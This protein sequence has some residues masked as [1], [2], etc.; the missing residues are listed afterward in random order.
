MATKTRKPTSRAEQRALLKLSPFELKDK[1]MA[2]AAETEEVAQF[3]MLN[4]GRGN[5]N[6]ICTTPREAFGTLLRFA[7]EESRRGVSMPDARPD[8]R[9]PGIGAAVRGVPGREPEAPGI[10]LLR[11]SCDYGV[12][13]LKF[14]PDTFAHEL[15]EG[16][17][18][19]MYPVPGRMLRCSERI[20]HEYLMQEMCDGSPPA[21]QV[22]PLRGRR[23]HRG[24]VLHLRLA[25]AE[26][27]A[28]SRRH[29]RPGRADVHA[30]HRDPAPRPLR[31]QGR[32]HRCGQGAASRR[33]HTWQY[34]DA[35]IDKLA[36]KRIKA[37]FL[38]NPS[39][40]PSFAMRPARCSG[41][42][43]S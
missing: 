14:D 5:P 1:L 21:G 43:S 20:V 37:F 3:P 36:D 2:L 30:L 7:L 16:I 9:K 42:S 35:E 19:D 4:A 33:H 18:G 6:W 13:K 39:N 17:I 10:K 22:R 23:R 25:D 12:K 31:L 24:D 26:R 29:H 11:E 38:V 34:S 40:P 41:W 28:A 32:P 8:A 15:A 27:P